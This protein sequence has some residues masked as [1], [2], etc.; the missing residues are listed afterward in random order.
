MNI[1]PMGDRVLV[2]MEQ[3]QE[4]TAGGIFIPQTAQEKTQIAEVL[5][6]GSDE[7]ITVKKGDKVMYDKYTGTSVKANGEEFLILHMSDILAIID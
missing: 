4:K 5:E 7:T 2:R 3:I 1:K 6:I